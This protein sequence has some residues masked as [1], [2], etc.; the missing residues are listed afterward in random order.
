[1]K[2]LFS[3]LLSMVMMFSLMFGVTGTSVYAAE[4]DTPAEEED[5]EEYVDFNTPVN[6]GTTWV[7]IVTAS[8]GINGNIAVTSVNMNQSRGDIQMLDSNGNQLWYGEDVVPSVG[9]ATFWCGSDVYK[10][11]VRYNYGSGTVSVGPGT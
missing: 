2:K 7:T 11:R 3:M 9:T 1:M 5:I 10:V 4:L 6:V 8:P